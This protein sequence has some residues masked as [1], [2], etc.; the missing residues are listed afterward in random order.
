MVA[1]DRQKVK[2]AFDK[3]DKIIKLDITNNRLIPNAMEPRA[4][5]VDYNRAPLKRLL[6]KHN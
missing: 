4:C 6:F 3:A 5:V 2:E 1:R